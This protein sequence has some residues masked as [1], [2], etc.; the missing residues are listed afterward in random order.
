MRIGNL[1]NRAVG[2]LGNS[3]RKVAQ[4]APGVRQIVKGADSLFGKN[5]SK[6]LDR[7]LGFAKAAEEEVE[8][9]ERMSPSERAAK[10][11][12]LAGQYATRGLE[13]LMRS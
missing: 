11:G 5:F 2:F 8:K 3:L 1:F 4:V 13:S 6:Y 12:G 9:F 7:G 10:L